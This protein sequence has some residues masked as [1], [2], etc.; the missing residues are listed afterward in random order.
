MNGTQPRRRFVSGALALLAG[1]WFARRATAAAPAE[2]VIEVTAR[3]FFYRPNEITVKAGAPVVLKITSVDFF[4]GFS[5]PD[6]KLRADLP[7]GEVTTVRFTA[8][9]QKGEIKF[10]CDN[11]CGDGHE[12]M[13]GRFIVSA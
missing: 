10:L 3:R 5:V 8:P 2:Q 6:L 7:P 9:K 11:F 12:E 4:H 13:H 1:G